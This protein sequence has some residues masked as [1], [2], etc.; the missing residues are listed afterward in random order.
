MTVTEIERRLSDSRYEKEKINQAE[1]LSKYKD[2]LKADLKL[3]LEETKRKFEE[4]I[5]DIPL[6]IKLLH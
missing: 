5:A 1:T 3:E 2:I 6:R 4:D